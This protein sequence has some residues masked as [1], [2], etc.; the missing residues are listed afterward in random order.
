MESSAGPLFAANL[1][2]RYIARFRALHRTIIMAAIVK[3]PEGPEGR[4]PKDWL[5]YYCKN[6]SHEAGRQRTGH[7]AQKTKW[8]PSLA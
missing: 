5:A 2:N 4:Y 8:W 7:A 1:A 3:T 6:I